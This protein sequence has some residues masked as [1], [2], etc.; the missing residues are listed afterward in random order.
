MTYI[1]LA[2][3]ALVLGLTVW[4]LWTEKD[5]RKQICAAMVAVPLLLRIL[6]IK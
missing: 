3:A 2:I 1:Y 6:L 5:P 4:N